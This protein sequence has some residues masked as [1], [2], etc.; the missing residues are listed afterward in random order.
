MSSRG[1]GDQAESEVFCNKELKDSNCPVIHFFREVPLALWKWLKSSEVGQCSGKPQESRWTAGKDTVCGHYGE[2][3]NKPSVTHLSCRSV[4]SHP[5]NKHMCIKCFPLSRREIL[6]RWL[7]SN[8]FNCTVAHVW[9]GPVCIPF[10]E[11]LN[12]CTNIICSRQQSADPTPSSR[13]CLASLALTSFR[14]DWLCPSW[15]PLFILLLLQVPV[16]HQ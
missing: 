6:E 10:G 7:A 1:K 11:I 4:S 14:S 12:T 16:G 2:N 5:Q 13:E 15:K 9:S 3:Q 8:L